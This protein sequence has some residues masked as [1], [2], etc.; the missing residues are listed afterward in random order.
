M[1]NIRYI[2]TL[3]MLLSCIR[4]SAENVYA[5][6]IRFKLPDSYT[7]LKSQQNQFEAVEKSS[8]HFIIISHLD[9]KKSD[10]SKLYASMDT[11]MYTIPSSE[12]ELQKTKTEWFFQWNKNY[13]KR[14]YKHQ[15]SEERI[16]TYTFSTD[17]QC[18][19]LLYT[20]YTE[21]DLNAVESMINSMDLNLDLWESLCYLYGCAPFYWILYGLLILIVGY[22]TWNTGVG[23]FILGLIMSI[24]ILLGTLW[25]DWLFWLLASGI[26]LLTMLLSPLILFVLSCIDD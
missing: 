14:Y 24:A 6:N 13:V 9:L 23:S 18:Y 25:G 19:C 22:T 12:Y 26:T 21:T 11:I 17:D 16:M 4:I 5:G 7:Q 1:K 15:N 3:T 2:I 20:Y 10:K 8:G